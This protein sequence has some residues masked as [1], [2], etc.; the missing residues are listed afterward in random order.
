MPSGL[1]SIDRAKAASAQLEQI[2]E[3]PLDVDD[4]DEVSYQPD[5]EKL[6]QAASTPRI[7]KRATER[8][9]TP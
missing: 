8:R 2:C 7:L 4:D 3:T 1:E 6:D 5:W 9:S